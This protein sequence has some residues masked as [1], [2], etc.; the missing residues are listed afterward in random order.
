[1]RFV[2]VIGVIYLVVGIIAL[3]TGFGFHQSMVDSARGLETPE[4][5]ML[6]ILSGATLSWLFLTKAGIPIQLILL[7]AWWRNGWQKPDLSVAPMMKVLATRFSIALL[8]IGSINLDLLIL[9]D[10]VGV[11]WQIENAITSFTLEYLPYLAFV[12]LGAWLLAWVVSCI[13]F[14]KALFTAPRVV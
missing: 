5:R 12:V 8:V 11:S 13:P 3:I 9:V 7:I 4:W 10:S 2:K 14:I 6:L 1:M